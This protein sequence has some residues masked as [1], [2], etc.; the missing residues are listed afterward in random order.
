M[1][2]WTLIFRIIILL[3]NIIMCLIYWINLS[4]VY[5]IYKGLYYLHYSWLVVY[6]IH[7][8]LKIWVSYL[9]CGL[10]LCTYFYPPDIT[11]SYYH[12]YEGCWMSGHIKLIKLLVQISGENTAPFVWILLTN[13]DVIMLRVINCLSRHTTILFTI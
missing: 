12:S 9:L 11:L 13:F 3:I 2:I 1:K 4:F 6:A 8:W 10:N 5:F 7:K